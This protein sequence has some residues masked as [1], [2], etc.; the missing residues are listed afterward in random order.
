MASCHKDTVW[1]MRGLMEWPCHD[2]MN[3][4]TDWW[5]GPNRMVVGALK[6]DPGM[7]QAQFHDWSTTRWMQ[8][9]ME[10]PR[11][12]M[13]AKAQPTDRRAMWWM[14]LTVVWSWHGIGKKSTIYALSHY[15]MDECHWDVKLTSAREQIRGP[16]T[17]VV[18]DEWKALLRDLSTIRTIL[19]QYIGKKH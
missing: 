18:Y 8:G 11:H 9:T 7:V 13:G 5:L 3:Y 10:W 1:C 6:S 15:T 2:T 14:D 4:G 17:W 12:C 16:R 19:E